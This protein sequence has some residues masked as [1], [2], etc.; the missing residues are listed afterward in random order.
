MTVPL[1]QHE[2]PPRVPGRNEV[3]QPHDIQMTAKRIEE[4]SASEM[5][6]LATDVQELR[7]RRAI[8]SRPQAIV[9]AQDHVM[10]VHR[11][12]VGCSRVRITDI[13]LEQDS[14]QAPGARISVKLET[15]GNRPV[16][17]CTWEWARLVVTAA[18]VRVHLDDLRCPSPRAV[19]SG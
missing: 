11:L 19:A 13:S 1:D 9:D 10:A 14:G 12:L 6:I 17:D 7:A 2:V 3:A 5:Q 4:L 18:P 8:M 15:G 16:D